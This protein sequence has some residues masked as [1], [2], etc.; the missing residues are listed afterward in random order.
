MKAVIS[1]TLVAAISSSLAGCSVGTA[2]YQRGPGTSAL[3]ADRLIQ[4]GEF[5]EFRGNYAAAQNSY[6]RALELIPESASLNR[7]I[8]LLQ[9][10]QKLQP[11]LADVPETSPQPED[12]RS[13]VASAVDRKLEQVLQTDPQGR[14]A[15]SSLPR[16]SVGIT[17]RPVSIGVS[18]DPFRNTDSLDDASLLGRQTPLF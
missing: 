15:S 9:Q 11:E 5:H 14:L 3:A 1:L 16:R 10:A 2:L 12:D 18:S 4:V 17:Q 13:V 6:Q 8:T 7:R